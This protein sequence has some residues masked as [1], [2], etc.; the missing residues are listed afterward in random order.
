M[1]RLKSKR[2]SG[3]FSRTGT[4]SDTVSMECAASAELSSHVLGNIALVERTAITSYSAAPGPAL[5]G[6]ENRAV[7]KTQVTATS[8][9]PSC[10]ELPR[11]TIGGLTSQRR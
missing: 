9:S 6:E 3:S 8:P 10:V 7:G 11:G 4:I 5:S 2:G 1:V